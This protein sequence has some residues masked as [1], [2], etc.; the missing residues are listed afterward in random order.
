LF[1]PWYSWNSAKVGIKHQSI[2]QSIFP[3]INVY[4]QT[5]CLHTWFFSFYLFYQVLL[6]IQKRRGKN[7]QYLVFKNHGKTRTIVMMV[8]MMKMIGIKLM[9]LYFVCFIFKLWKYKNNILQTIHYTDTYKFDV[10]T[11]ISNLVYMTSAQSQQIWK[12]S[13]FKNNWSKKTTG[14]KQDSQIQLRLLTEENWP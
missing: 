5:Y 10:D 4:K 14:P 1:T 6:H 3:L 8:K 12:T 13:I 11:C 9:I 2:N 7:R